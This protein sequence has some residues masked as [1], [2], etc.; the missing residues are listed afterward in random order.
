MSRPIRYLLNAVIIL[1]LLLAGLGGVGWWIFHRGLPQLDGAHQI[2]DLKS[3]VTV[4]RDA[5]W[6]EIKR[7]EVVPGDVVRLSA[8]D[9]VPADGQLLEAR[10]DVSHALR[11][12]R[13]V[14]HE[15]GE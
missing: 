11:Q 10:D 15:G 9:L 8:G 2:A 13:I 6:Q 14:Q 12:G 1:A 5:N 7:T 4:L 3:E